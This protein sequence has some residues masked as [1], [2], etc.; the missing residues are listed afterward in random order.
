MGQP[1]ANTSGS[2]GRQKNRQVPGLSAL[3]LLDLDFSAINM[4]SLLV[5]PDAAP[6]VDRP[7]SDNE[8]AQSANNKNLAP[9]VITRKQ[10]LVD[11]FFAAFNS[12]EI[13]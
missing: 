5:P 13:I 7:A 10:R 6:S 11:S 8:L 4:E 9:S 1:G 12:A 3:G 2:T